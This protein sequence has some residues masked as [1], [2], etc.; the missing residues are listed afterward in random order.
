MSRRVRHEL[1]YDAPAAD[2][3]AM[4]GDPAFRE[5]VCVAT[6][7]I[8]H[9]VTISQ[10]GAGMQV[11]VEQVQAAQGL[12]SFA[13]RF[14]G[15][16]IQIVQQETWHDANGADLE[17]TIPGKPG[18]MR[19]TIAL[20]QSD[21]GTTEVVTLDVTVRI[22]LVGGKIEGLIADLLVKSLKV[23]NSVGRQYLGA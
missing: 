17:V 6:G 9:T 11:V 23:E 19:G 5:Q 13:R 12:P 15:D 1:K 18:N 2:V 21:N 20:D 4:L 7:V 16:E 8:R 3:Y 10:A 14:V 22:P